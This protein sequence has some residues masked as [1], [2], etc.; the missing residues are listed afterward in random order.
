MNKKLNE[1]YFE[2]KKKYREGVENRPRTFKKK[3]I[4][5]VITVIL[6]ITYTSISKSCEKRNEEKKLEISQ[7]TF[8]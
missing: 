5:L 7:V 8:E 1:Q 4:N 2:T 3:I 6:I